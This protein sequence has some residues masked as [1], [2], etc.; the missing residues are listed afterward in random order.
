[1]FGIVVDIIDYCF[2]MIK[3]YIS[4]EQL[5]VKGFQR[6][7]QDGVYFFFEVFFYCKRVVVYLFFEGFIIGNSSIIFG[8]SYV[9]Y[10]IMF[11]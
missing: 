10:S 5:I 2:G 4:L 3:Y 6:I 8:E 1:M 9:F 11:C 7:F